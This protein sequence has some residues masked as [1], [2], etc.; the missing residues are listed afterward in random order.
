MSGKRGK[1]TPFDAPSQITEKYL[2]SFSA[3]RS[4]E[5]TQYSES[6]REQSGSDSTDSP[7]G[8]EVASQNIKIE[9]FE[10]PKWAENGFKILGGLAALVA[11]LAV[12]VKVCL[13]AYGLNKTVDEIGG[14]VDTLK[15]DVEKVDLKYFNLYKELNNIQTDIRLKLTE[16]FGKFDR[17]QDKIYSFE[18]EARNNNE[19]TKGAPEVHPKP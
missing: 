4:G 7:M 12:I 2:E 8:G 13:F 15:E 10:M 18:G 9:K 3:A 11:I 5:T 17:I 1:K 16:L 6:G 14:K 19:K